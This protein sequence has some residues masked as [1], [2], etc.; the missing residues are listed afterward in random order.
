MQMVDLKVQ[1]QSLKSAIDTRIETVLNHGRYVM[2]PEVAE[3][4]QDLSAFCGVKNAV[5]VSSGTDALLI[6]LM[7]L[8]IGSGDEVITTAFS[9]IATAEM[10]ALL[11][12][13]P[14]FVDI[15]PGTF[16]IDAALIEAAI[17]AR[18]RAIIPVSMYGQCADMDAINII[19]Q[20]VG[21][22]VIEDAA[23][24]FG[25]TYK[26]RRSGRLS[27]L[28]C[29]SFYP[30]KPLGCY[31]DGG[32]CFTDDDELAE[33]VRRI[34]D[35]GQDG[36]YHHVVLGL[37]ARMDTIQAAILL[38]KMDAFPGELARRSEIGRAY[39]ECL[40]NACPS[41]KTPLIAAYN[42]SVYAQYTI[43]V[44]SR[45]RVQVK[46]AEAGIPTVVHY[47]TPL[48]LQPALSSFGWTTGNCPQAEG[49]ARDV[50]SLPMHAYLSAEDI[51]RVVEAFTNVLMLA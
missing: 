23:Q 15:E 38:A 13:T 22:A 14:V 51:E 12:A 11:G 4:E 32:A 7:A 26:G 36:R 42:K 40:M 5:A 2:G 31:G 50:L 6:A 30:A 16:N 35:H 41:V 3:L 19:A 21:I 27:T 18:T 37:N 28:A 10:I 29:T 1:Y 46:L 44:A 8:D 47:P 9:F 39:D 20:R 24:S 25:A 49:A 43:R 17:T 48:H 33:R 34:R 45:D